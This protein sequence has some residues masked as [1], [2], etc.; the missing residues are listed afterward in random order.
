MN[1]SKIETKLA[2]S[3]NC[4]YQVGLVAGQKHCWRKSLGFNLAVSRAFPTIGIAGFGPQFASILP[5]FLDFFVKSRFQ[6][7]VERLKFQRILCSQEPLQQF[8]DFIVHGK[9]SVTGECSSSD[10]AP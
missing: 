7:A 2:G 5:Q 10:E 1:S 8:L 6:L 3:W 4:A 9:G